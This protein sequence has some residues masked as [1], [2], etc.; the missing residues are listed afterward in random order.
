MLVEGSAPKPLFTHMLC[1]GA[2]FGCFWSRISLTLSM[3]LLFLGCTSVFAE[4]FLCV[5]TIDQ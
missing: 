1:G 2:S 5:G 3:L 4:Y